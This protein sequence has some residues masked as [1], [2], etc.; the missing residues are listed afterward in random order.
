MHVVTNYERFSSYEVFV[1]STNFL[2]TQILAGKGSI[3]KVHNIYQETVTLPN[4]PM[5]FD[6]T[7]MKNLTSTCLHFSLQSQAPLHR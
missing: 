4:L 1:T 2:G 6:A 7:E 5:F 3:T